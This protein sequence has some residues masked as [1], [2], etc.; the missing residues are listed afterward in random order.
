MKIGLFKLTSCSG[1]LLEFLNMFSLKPDLLN[2][3]EFYSLLLSDEEFPS[4]YDAV[5]IE[6]SVSSSELES[7]VKNLRGRS[8]Y[9]I[10][11][12]H[13]SLQGGLQNNSLEYNKPVTGVVKIDYVLPG[14]PVDREQLLNLVLKIVMGGLDIRLSEPLCVEC[15]RNNYVCVLIEYRKPCLGPLTRSGCGA[16]CPGI[17]RECI[18]CNSLRED[19]TRREIE[20]FREKLVEYSCPLIDYSKYT[21][22]VR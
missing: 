2:E 19:V 17:G 5:F 3:I 6:G 20:L 1:C 12:G 4:S 18:G 7:F 8:K 22:V 21:S 14:C 9:L 15:K 11:I 10:A 16:I 13:C